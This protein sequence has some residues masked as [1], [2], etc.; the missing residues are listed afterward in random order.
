[1]LNFDNVRMLSGLERR[2]VLVLMLVQSR[3]TADN[4]INQPENKLAA[5]LK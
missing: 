2:L 3:Y 1:M 5:R 4:F